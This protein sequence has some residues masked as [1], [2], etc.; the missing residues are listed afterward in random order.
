MYNLYIIMHSY[1]LL[2]IIYNGNNL[3]LFFKLLII[4]E[5]SIIFQRAV[6]APEISDEV[7]AP[8]FQAR[9]K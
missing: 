7:S 6:F 4:S 2:Y 1:N 3:F 5:N 8:K 9:G